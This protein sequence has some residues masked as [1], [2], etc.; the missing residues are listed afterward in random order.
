MRYAFGDHSSGDL[1]RDV[2][3]LN[4]SCAR[5]W[6]S[7]RKKRG[8]G[9]WRAHPPRCRARDDARRNWRGRW[10]RDR[11]RGRCWQ[12][13]RARRGGW[14]RGFLPVVA[15][16]DSRV[17]FRR[18]VFHL[19]L[20]LSRRGSEVPRQIAQRLG[21]QIVLRVRKEG[22]RMRPIPRN[23]LLRR[24]HGLLLRDGRSEL[25]Q[26]CR[27]LRPPAMPR[28]R[29]GQGEVVPV[30]RGIIVAGGLLMAVALA[31][32]GRK[33]ESQPPAPRPL[34]PDLPAFIPARAGDLAIYTLDTRRLANLSPPEVVAVYRSA[35]NEEPV[36]SLK[37]ATTPVKGEQQCSSGRVVQLAGTPACLWA[38]DQKSGALISWPRCTVQFAKGVPA[39]E[40]ISSAGAMA[41]WIQRSEARKISATE[42]RK[43]A[44]ELEPAALLQRRRDRESRKQ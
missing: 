24:L 23:A 5:R 42:A 3:R 36:A 29:R 11:A 43:S 7:R 21:V 13:A 44:E 17:C 15:G 33:H 28:Q 22:H 41:E 20:R 35:S 39:A 12:W 14:R 31:M 30:N 9:R 8:G 27:L 10:R 26:R 40:A 2:R 32:L 1:V 4:G 19:V 37:C 25:H 38:E 6:R 16:A 18:G 34:A